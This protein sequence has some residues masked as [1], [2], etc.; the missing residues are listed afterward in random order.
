MKEKN[1]KGKEKNSKHTSK[2]IALGMV[3]NVFEDVMRVKE[4]SS[5]R[6]YFIL[7]IWGQPPWWEGERSP[8]AA[9]IEPPPARRVL[10]HAGWTN[11]RLN[12]QRCQRIHKIHNLIFKESPL[13]SQVIS[14]CNKLKGH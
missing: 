4:L 9:L 10:M 7:G 5:K 6:G 8:K 1:S 13:Y 2:Y 3:M 11:T 14:M 12:F